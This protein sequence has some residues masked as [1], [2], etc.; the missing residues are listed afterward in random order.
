MGVTLAIPGDFPPERMWNSIVSGWVAMRLNA[1][2]SLGLNVFE[3]SDREEVFVA[4]IRDLETVLRAEM[5][6]RADE[7]KRREGGL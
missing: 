1:L 7:G 4:F 6:K 3:P 2:G 5:G